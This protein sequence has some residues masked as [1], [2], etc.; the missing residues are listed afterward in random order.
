MNGR[1]RIISQVYLEPNRRKGGDYQVAVLTE[2]MQKLVNS[3]RCFLATASKDGVPNIGPKGSVIVLD[4][5]TLAFGELTAKQ[6]YKNLLENPRVAIAVVDHD[7]SSGYRFTGSVKLETGG[8]LYEQFARRF[9]EMKLPKPVAAVKVNV[10]GIYDLSAKNPG[11][12][13]S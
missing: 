11:G 3:R 7:K 1:S 5:S 9:S 2:Q 6:S 12:R 4:N 10:E 8:E 13:I